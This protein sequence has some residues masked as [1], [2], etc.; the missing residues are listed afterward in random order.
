M[1]N[2]KSNLIVPILVGTAIGVTIGILFAPAK[3]K[4]TR[5]KIRTKT[6]DTAHHLSEQIGHAKEEI[7][8]FALEKKAE[9]ESKMETKI[10]NLSYKAEDI[11]I[12]LEKKL[13]DLKK[14][15]ASL[16]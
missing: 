2:T 13:E 10:S 1:E 7:T 14:K 8:K 6:L 11:I 12:Q 4:T 9:L 5:D 15:N 3:G 16:H